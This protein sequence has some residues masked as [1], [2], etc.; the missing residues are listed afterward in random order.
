[1]ESFF[2]VLE[3]RI[4]SSSS[5]LCIGLDPHTTELNERSPEYAFRFCKEIIEQTHPYV[6][7]YKPNIAFFEA[8]GPIGLN[9]LKEV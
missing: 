9:I 4:R 7:A 1:M 3:K 6:A 2:E 5:F 8:I